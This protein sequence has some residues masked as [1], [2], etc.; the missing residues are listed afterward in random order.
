MSGQL[1]CVGSMMLCKAN[2]HPNKRVWPQMGGENRISV[3]AENWGRKRTNWCDGVS[4]GK[5][6]SR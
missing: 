6:T 1:G 5:G 3:K 2:A 4:P